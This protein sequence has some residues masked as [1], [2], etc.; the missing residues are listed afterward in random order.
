MRA[1]RIGALN[2][3]AAHQEKKL[4]A[5]KTASDQTRHALGAAA[6]QTAGARR[7]SSPSSSRCATRSAF[8]ADTL[9]QL[10]SQDYT[11]E[12]FEILVADGGS[13]D[14]TRRI[15]AAY[16]KRFRQRPPARQ[17]G[18]LSSAGRN[19]AV[20]GCAG[21][22]VL[23]IDGHCEIDNPRLLADL[24]VAFA[25]SGADCVGRPQPLDV[26]G[27]TP[28]AAGHRRGRSSR[29]GHHPASH[30]YSDREG[31][32][33]PQSVAVAYRRAVFDDVGLFDERSTPAR[34][35]S[36]TTASPGPG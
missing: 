1:T 15:V 34:T 14:A 18:R 31:F 6:E 32:V 11:A 3:P 36:S 2:E 8:I 17:S 29:L 26:T 19:V 4:S 23:L 9:D 12:R 25:R 16:A 33:P 20:A 21:E 10:C 28:L 35:W 7:R 22:I 24:A 13:T 30:I 5:A 27:A